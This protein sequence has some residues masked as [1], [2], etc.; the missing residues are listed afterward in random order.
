MVIIKIISQQFIPFGIYARKIINFLIAEFTYKKNH[1]GIYETEISQ[2]KIYLGKKPVD[3]V[4]KM[5]GKRNVGSSSGKTILRQL[6]AILNSHMAIATGYKQI[7]PNDDELLA[8]DR[9]QFAL[10]E[11][12]I[13]E[14][15][16]NHN[17]KV[18]ENWQEEIYV[19]KDLAQILSQH[20]MPLDSQ[21]Y[22]QITS[23][24]ELDV[25][26]YYTYQNYNNL[27]KNINSIRYSWEEIMQ[28]FGRGY[29]ENSQGIANFRN[30]F[31]KCIASLQVKTSIDISAPVDS[32][33]IIFK[34]NKTLIANTSVA[35]IKVWKEVEYELYKP[36]IDKLPSSSSPAHINSDIWTAVLQKYT[37]T[38]KFDKNALEYIKSA[39]DKDEM[40]TLKTIEYTLEQK[41]QNPSAFI[42]KA[43]A[44]N[45]LKNYDSFNQK[46]SQLRLIFN[47][48]DKDKA[49][50]FVTKANKA[51]AFLKSRYSPEEF[52]VEIVTLIYVGLSRI[53]DINTFINELEGSKYKIY[54]QRHIEL[55]ILCND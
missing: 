21:I 46:I 15:L 7:N 41:P 4:E 2:R 13:D 8:A 54:F 43:L 28:L 55:I 39:F 24:M 26:Q 5:C 30:D 44:E 23:P 32:K 22:N 37:L 45:W 25:Y 48:F 20:I 18:T 19:S 52:S 36:I 16:I 27:K 12:G 1:P 51:I 9:Y 29:A 31:R 34:P 3:F 10:I 42:K 40:Y 47:K 6:E 14:P 50:Q 53:A 17:F 33:H 49:S 38:S 11:A 35:E